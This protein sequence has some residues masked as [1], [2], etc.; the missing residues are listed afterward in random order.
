MTALWSSCVM[1]ES[2]KLV[3]SDLSADEIVRRAFSPCTSLEALLSREVKLPAPPENLRKEMVRR[4]TA[5]VEEARTILSA[6][7]AA[8]A[9]KK[10]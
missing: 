9:P 8:T 3:T 6:P 10:P 4:I 5:A 7:P 2:A 1:G